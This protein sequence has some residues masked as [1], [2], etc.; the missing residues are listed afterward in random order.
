MGFMRD[1]LGAAFA[2]AL[3]GGSSAAANAAPEPLLVTRLQDPDPNYIPPPEPKDGA[4]SADDADQDASI[5]QAMEDLGRAIGQAGM[6][7]R[8]KVQAKCREGIPADVPAEQRYAW[9]ARCSYQRY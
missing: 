7:I 3:L 9:E 8:Q 5:D 4:R 6:V 2:V 1:T